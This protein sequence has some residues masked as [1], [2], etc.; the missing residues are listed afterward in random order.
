[1][2]LPAVPPPSRNKLIVGFAIIA[3]G[4]LFTLENFGIAEARTILRF[5]PLV[6]V[7]I[8]IGCLRPKPPY[9]TFASIVWISIGVLILFHEFRIWRVT[10]GKLWPLVLVLV[11]I[12]FVRTALERS[13]T[14]LTLGGGGDLA[15]SL[16]DWVAFGGIERRIASPTFTGGDVAA[17]CGGFEIDLRQAA[18]AGDEAV[19]DVFAWWGGGEIRVPPEWDV[20][21][22]VLPLFG[23]YSDETVHPPREEGKPVKRFVVTG[24]V[25]MGGVGVKN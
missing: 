4:I 8:G 2:A 21:M 22:R 5:W 12:R 20:T 1:M 15:S 24:T 18:I 7:G 11:G 6:L 19:L 9:V 14:S 3:A 17:F 16:S 25:V 10:L 13:R 23:G